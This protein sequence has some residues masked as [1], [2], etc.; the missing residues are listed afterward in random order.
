MKDCYHTGDAL[1]Q[2][3]KRIAEL[4]QELAKSINKAAMIAYDRFFQVGEGTTPEA[5]MALSIYKAIKE[6]S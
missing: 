6:A 1:T 5:K 3:D 4:E 2:K